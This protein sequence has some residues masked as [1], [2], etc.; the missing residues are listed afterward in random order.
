[1]IGL[2][3]DPAESETLTR[4]KKDIRLPLRTLSERTSPRRCENERNEG[5]LSSLKLSQVFE[6]EA[7]VHGV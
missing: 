3:Q 6:T 4:K 5:E 1:M 7:R 2:I